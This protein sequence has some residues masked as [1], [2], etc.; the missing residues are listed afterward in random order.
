MH[1]VLHFLN[2]YRLA[3]GIALSLM[4]TELMVELFQPFL[5]SKIIDEGIMNNDLSAVLYWGAVMVVLSLIAFAAG[6]V[7]SFYAAHVSQSYGYDVREKIYEKVQSFSFAVFN[8]FPTSS[9]ITRL[10]NDVT[11]LQNTVFMSLRIM[12]RAPLLLIG[13]LVMALFVNVQLALIL[14]IVVPVL[15]M[16]LMWVLQRAGGLFR[17]VQQKLD[18]VNN[19]MQENL[20]GMRLIKAFLR[21]D[22]EVQRFDRSGSELMEQTRKALRFIEISMPV[23]LLAMNGS[24]LAV[25]W[26]GSHDVR[27]G[28]A[29]VGDVVAIINY[30]IRMS[31]ALSIFSMIIMNFS[32][33]RASAQRISEVLNTEDEQDESR[34]SGTSHTPFQKGQIEFRSVSFHYPGSQLPIL[35]KVSFIARPGE[36]V[37]ILGATGSGKTSLFQLI[38]RLY[39][40]NEGQIRIDGIDI[41]IMD[42]EQL[43]RQIA[44]VPQEVLLFTGTVRQNIAWGKEDATMEEIVTAAQH[45]QLHETIM[46]LPHQYDTMLGQRGVNLS[47]GQKQ[48]LSIARALVRKSKVL[49]LDDSTSALDA[50]TEARLLHALKQ[51]ACTTLL[52]TQKMSAAMNADQIL[53]FEDG[54]L[55]DRGTHEELILRSEL[56]QNI[57]RSQFGEEADYA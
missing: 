45:A 18:D 46:R 8:R 12:L 15:I 55:L 43:R 36:T 37:A 29:S 7:N 49:L 23:I 33:A 39:P 19:V 26:Y 40:V 25:L 20:A 17:L 35:D 13:G 28:S 11:Q 47:G 50:K 57:Y 30:A 38:P 1:N 24:I 21:K 22:Y 51:Y 53:L 52:I 34:N 32:R 10:T 44:Y 54:Q 48:R 14:V 41:S 3:I 4:L 42:A 2:R 6:I 31:V 16:F 9:L 27:V 56:Y 5:I